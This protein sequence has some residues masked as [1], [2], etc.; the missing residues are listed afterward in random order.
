MYLV[1][2][3]TGSV[4]REVVRRLLNGGRRFVPPAE[5]AISHPVEPTPISWELAGESPRD[6]RQWV[7][8]HIAEFQ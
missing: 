3:A 6:Y 1:T 2:G 5:R 4:G 8:D 7:S